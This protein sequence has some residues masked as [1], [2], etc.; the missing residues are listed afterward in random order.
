M[1][2]LS[3]LAEQAA[4]C[5]RCDL[6]RHAS[7]TVFGEG[8]SAAGLMLV[9]ETPGDVEDKQGKPFVGPA[10]RVL[11]R[12]LRDSGIERERLYLTNAVKH[13]KFEQSGKRRLHRPP[14]AR[15]KSPTAVVNASPMAV[16]GAVEA[17]G[18]GAARLGRSPLVLDVR[19]P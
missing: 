16:S 13:F 5:T 6:Y 8:P 2:S 11:D 3:E 15:A 14:A 12:A 19:R 17:S 7:R 9:G 1:T 4:A 18:S 10:G